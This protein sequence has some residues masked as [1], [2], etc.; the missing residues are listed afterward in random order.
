MRVDKP[1]GFYEDFFRSESL[2]VKRIV[3]NPG[4]SLSLQKH[5]HRRELWLLVS[6]SGSYIY[7]DIVCRFGVD[8]PVFIDSGVVH[9]IVNDSGSVVLVVVEV[10]TGCCR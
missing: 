7:D 1:W 3:V 5:Q 8:C 9:R 10:Q 4:C 6:G 2:V